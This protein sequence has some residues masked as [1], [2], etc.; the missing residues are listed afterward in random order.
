MEVILMEI[1][2]EEGGPVVT[3]LIRSGIGPLAGEG[4][5]EAFGLAVGLGTIR[6]GEAV[7]EAEFLA[8][9]GKE[10][11][12]VSGAAI[13]QQALDANAMSRVKGHGL[14]E[15]GQGTGDLF[16]RAESGEGE[17]AVIIDGDVET[18]STMRI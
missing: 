1:S 14:L 16:I 18:G 8:G 6:S 15:G 3:G 13:G 2:R 9:G 11:G 5:D 12:A 10:F 17:A 4:L 7:G